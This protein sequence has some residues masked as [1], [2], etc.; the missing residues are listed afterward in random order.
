MILCNSSNSTCFHIN[1]TPYIFVCC[2]LL[3]CVELLAVVV[4]KQTDETLNKQ[5]DET[6]N[7]QTDETLKLCEFVHLGET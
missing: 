6:L 5:T 1:S 7:K 3:D 2:C 4:V